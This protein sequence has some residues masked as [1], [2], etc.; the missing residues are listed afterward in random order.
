MKFN[1]H[2]SKQAQEIIFSRKVSKSFGPYVHFDNN[3]V[4]KGSVCKHVGIILDSKWSFEDY[5]KYLMA[6]VN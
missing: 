5:L 1:P 3:L 6:K 2:L 4:N